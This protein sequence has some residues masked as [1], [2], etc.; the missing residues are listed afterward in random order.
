MKSQVTLQEIANALGVSAMTVSR[1]LNDSDKINK[2]TKKKIIKKANEMG[3]T[4]NQI[5][6]SLISQKSNTIGVVIPE[7]HH[8]FFAQVVSGIE[9]VIYENGYHL[10]LTNS[11]ESF[12]REKDVT[13][14]LRS[15]R[16][17]G[18]LISCAEDSDDI[19]Y[20]KNLVESGGNIVFFDRCIEDIGASCISV[21]DR[22]GARKITEHFI[23]HG[24]S[25]IAHLSGPPGISISKKRQE[26]YL[27]AMSENGLQDKQL[28]KVAGFRE[29]S[30]YEAMKTLIEET[31]KDHP[32]AV[33]AVNDPVAFGAIKAIKEKGLR[34]PEDI[35]IA[36]FS[37]DMRAE[38]MSPPLSTV[39]QPAFQ[40]GK[41]AAEKLIHTIENEDEPV[42][43]IYIDTK[44]V[45]RESCG[46]HA[47]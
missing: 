46:S 3:Y 14:A 27:E 34:I 32:R 39:G 6:K 30:G 37:D 20:Y 21:K 44:L 26:G 1:A 15:R 25:N 35:A 23:E 10:L 2:N 43:S 24:F 11:S 7:I 19:D 4:P 17:D 16:V 31:G 8:M 29:N 5:A 18:I 12:E 38:L 33:F 41:K 28:V 42:E 45:I 36:G 13:K 47:D 40:I 22:V 9:S